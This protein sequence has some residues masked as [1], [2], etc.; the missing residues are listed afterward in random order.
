MNR[1]ADRLLNSFKAEQ[2]SYALESLRVPSM[3]NEFEYG[4][5]VGYIQGLER[6]IA[7]LLAALDEERNGERDLD[8]RL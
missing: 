6:A 3:K 8:A 5:R 2:T 7:I 4:L 1:I